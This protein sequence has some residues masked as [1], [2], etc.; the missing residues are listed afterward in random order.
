MWRQQDTTTVGDFLRFLRSDG[1]HNIFCVWVEILLGCQNRSVFLREQ[2]AIFFSKIQFWIV[3]ASSPV[4]IWECNQNPWQKWKFIDSS[5]TASSR[6]IELGDNTS[7]SL[8]TTT[9]YI[10]LFISRFILTYLDLCLEEV[11]TGLQV[12]TSSCDSDESLDWYLVV[13][14]NGA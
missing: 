4:V 3:D 1:Y 14:G 13:E 2:N 9:I 8:T 7:A 11:N 12:H 6:K 10:Y 5:A